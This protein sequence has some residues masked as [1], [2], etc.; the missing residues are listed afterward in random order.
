MLMDRP[1]PLGETA[2]SRMSRRVVGGYYDIIAPRGD[3]DGMQGLLLKLWGIRH[4]MGAWGELIRFW[5]WVLV[6]CMACQGRREGVFMYE[7]DQ[8]NYCM[9]RYD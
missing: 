7:L 1:G 5:G 6:G 9:V 3:D 4:W 8:L 2:V